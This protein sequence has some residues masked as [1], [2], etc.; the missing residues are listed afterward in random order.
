MLSSS[1]TGVGS[2]SHRRAHEFKN[3]FAVQQRDRADDRRTQTVT[4]FAAH[5]R[6]YLDKS[7]I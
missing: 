2:S 3:E 6:R 4:P 1:V 5:P 7:T